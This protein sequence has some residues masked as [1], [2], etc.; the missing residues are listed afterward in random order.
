MLLSKQTRLLAA[1]DH[2][3]IFLDPDPDPATSWTERARMFALPSSSWADYNAK[4]IS[5]GGGVFARSLKSIPISAQVK[6]MLEI[7]ADAMAPTE[8]INAILKSQAELLYLGGIG[9]YVKAQREANADVGDRATMRCGSTA[10]TCGSRSWA[11]ARTS[12]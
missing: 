5:K 3:H 7:K 12:A 9:T 8:L 11:R 4:L 1:F 6:A 2:R 10:A